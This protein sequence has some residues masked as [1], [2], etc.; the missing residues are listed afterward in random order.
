[1]VLLNLAMLLI[2]PLFAWVIHIYLRHG[3]MSGR[4]KAVFLVV[5]LVLINLCAIVIS[6]MRGVGGF[7]FEGMTLSYRLKYMGIG[8]VLGFV[9]P[10]FVCLVTEDQITL[11]GFRRYTIRFIKD[12]RK[13]FHYAIYS[14][15]A[16]LRAE[17]ANSYLNWMWWLIEP[18]CT[19]LIY[20]VIFGFV[21]NASEQYYP[22]FIFIGITMWSFFS[23]SISG[24]VD[25]VRVNKAIVTKVYMPKYI[26]LLSKMFVNFFKM[27]ISFG[28]VLVMMIAYRVHI[29]IYVLYAIPIVAVLFLFTFGV[30]TILM[31]YGVYVN[32]LSYITQ[33]VLNMFMYFTGTFYSIGRRLPEPFGEILETFNPVAFLIAN[34]RN[35]LIYGAPVPFGFLVLWAFISVVIIAIGVFIVYSNENSYVKVI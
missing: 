25:M 30:G 12:L 32:D 23:R 2:P 4:R 35:A 5:Y 15:S 11:G 27:M 1:M 19:M 24:S 31:H 13:Y 21:F 20:T 6:F 9:I 18:V 8:C 16:D 26:L 28:V 22:I 7:D 17:V 33:I 10:F 14:A 29:T 34:M 3:D